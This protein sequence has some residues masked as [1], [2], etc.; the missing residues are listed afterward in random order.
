MTKSLYT[1]DGRERYTDEALE[2][3]TQLARELRTHFQKF[4]NAGYGVREI[5]L[6]MHDCITGVAHEVL[7][8]IQVKK[9]KEIHHGDPTSKA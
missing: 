9:S 2:L 1:D 4:M 5:S 8:G 7:L 3:D 6:V